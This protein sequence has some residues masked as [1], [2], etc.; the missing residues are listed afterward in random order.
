LDF[1]DYNQLRLTK[2]K[3]HAEK[4]SENNSRP[5]IIPFD[6]SEFMR[7]DISIRKA[8]EPPIIRENL[9]DEK[10]VVKP[11]KRIDPDNDRP[12]GYDNDI[13]DPDD[14]P[15]TPPSNEIQSINKNE[16]VKFL[17]DTY[18]GSPYDSRNRK[19]ARF[20]VRSITF[21]S[22]LIGLVFTFVWYAFPGKFISIRADADLTSRYQTTY[23][24]ID[25][26]KLLM[27]DY[28]SSSTVLFQDDIA[29]SKVDIDN[30]AEISTPEANGN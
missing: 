24:Y 29:K 28:S 4:E 11:T 2:F 16:I 23:K 14:E 9:K 6:S 12:T 3:L 20:V 30:S 21:L 15:L 10:N 8:L 17:E 22:V 18:I 13:Y 25:P 7:N 1:S 26:D 19:Q 27:D 5:P